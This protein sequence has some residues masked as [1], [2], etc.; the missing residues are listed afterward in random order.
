MIRSTAL[1]L[2]VL[3]LSSCATMLPI[4]KANSDQQEQTAAAANECN[5]RDFVYATDLPKGSR[6]LGP[7]AVEPQASDEDTFLELRR[8]ICEIGGDALS[9][10]AW[11]KEPS[12]QGAKLTANAWVLP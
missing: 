10:A 4:K 2:A 3:A 9:Q 1:I 5:V 11:V 12:E 7:V 8:R 6:P